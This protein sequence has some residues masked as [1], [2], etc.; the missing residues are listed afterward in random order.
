MLLSLIIAGLVVLTDR[1]LGKAVNIS[2]LDRTRINLKIFYS[3]LPK[4]F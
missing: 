1:M 2:D 3:K 4:F